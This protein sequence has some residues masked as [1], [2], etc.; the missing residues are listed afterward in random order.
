MALPNPK[1]SP[2]AAAGDLGIAALLNPELVDDLRKKKKED[3]EKQ[4]NAYGMT[5]LSVYGG[6]ASKMLGIP[7]IGGI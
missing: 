6:E 5:G 2:F 7:A 3:M 1:N 4:R